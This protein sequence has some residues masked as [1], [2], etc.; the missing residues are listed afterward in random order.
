MYKME[1]QMKDPPIKELAVNSSTFPLMAIGWY[2]WHWA[3]GNVC[4]IKVTKLGHRKINYPKISYLAYAYFIFKNQVT[5]SKGTTNGYLDSN[6]GKQCPNLC[7]SWKTFE[8][9]DNCLPH[10]PWVDDP[11]LAMTCNGKLWINTTHL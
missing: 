2:V 11:N 6:C 3:S 4:V 5:S 9:T 10:C 1:F 7:Q 8:H